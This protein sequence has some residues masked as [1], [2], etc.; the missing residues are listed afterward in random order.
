MEGGEG[1]Y[2]PPPHYVARA[3]Q[4][5]ERTL[6]RVP[7]FVDLGETVTVNV[8]LRGG[9]LSG[10]GAVFLIKIWIISARSGIFTTRFGSGSRSGHS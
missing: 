1:L 5:R 6:G 3:S 10:G 9:G 8:P 7:L 4:S 2:T